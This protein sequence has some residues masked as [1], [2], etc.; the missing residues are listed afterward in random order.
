M[1]MWGYRRDV[2]DRGRESLRILG[3]ILTLLPEGG[4]FKVGVKVGA[5]EVGRE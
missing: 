2:V 4:N 1:R 3:S 5:E